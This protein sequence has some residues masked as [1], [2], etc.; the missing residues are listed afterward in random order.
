FYPAHHTLF[1]G[2][3]GFGALPYF[4]PVFLASGNPTLAINLTC[5]GCIVLTAWTLHL[6]TVRWT[7]E[8]FAGFAA[9]APY[10]MNPWVLWGFIP[11]PPAYAVLQY[12]PLIVLFAATPSARF[13]EALRLLP[14][15]VLQAL[16]DVAYIAPAV[17]AP[18]GLLA[19]VR[20]VRTRTRAA[21]ARLLGVLA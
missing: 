4:L 3:T 21:G 11:S 8:P 13:R 2:D 17:F 15:I 16:A 14:L 19:V 1:Y 18:L 6:V 10:L 7:G 20:L 9:A 5:F 12:L